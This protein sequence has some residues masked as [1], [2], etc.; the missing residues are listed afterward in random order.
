MARPLTGSADTEAVGR[1]RTL[2]VVTLTCFI[3][4]V[5][6]ETMPCRRQGVYMGVRP[7][8]SPWPWAESA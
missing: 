1:R 5:H 8:M 7:A 6:G 3:T 4:L 2:G